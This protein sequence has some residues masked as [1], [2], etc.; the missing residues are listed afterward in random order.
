MA[1]DNHE[2]LRVW[3][4]IIL[5]SQSTLRPKIKLSTT[6]KQHKKKKKWKHFNGIFLFEIKHRSNAN[7]IACIKTQGEKR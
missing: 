5:E 1:Q 4:E 3:I 2:H 6:D 7:D